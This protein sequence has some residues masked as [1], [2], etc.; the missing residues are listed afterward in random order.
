MCIIMIEMVVMG[1]LA[2]TGAL[3]GGG[4]HNEV[5][6]GVRRVNRD[7]KVCVKT[8]NCYL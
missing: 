3:R 5:L 4:C 2:I 6:C 7:V 8:S 1:R